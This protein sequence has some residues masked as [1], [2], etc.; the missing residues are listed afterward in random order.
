MSYETAHF[1]EWLTCNN[2]LSNSPVFP[3]DLWL[4]CTCGLMGF[5][6][7]VGWGQ[8]SRRDYRKCLGI[9][10]RSRRIKQGIKVNFEYKDRKKKWT[11]QHCQMLFLPT[12]PFSSS[13]SDLTDVLTSCTTKA[14]EWT[15]S[16][17]QE[18]IWSFISHCTFL[19]ISQYVVVLQFKCVSW[20]RGFYP[21]FSGKGTG[22]WIS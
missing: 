9:N 18:I 5:H 11:E 16:N 4:L 19:L 15:S 6:V 14:T 2:F 12:S 20:N 10:R 17:N 1:C 21:R 13:S 8:C 3:R 7:K 22:L